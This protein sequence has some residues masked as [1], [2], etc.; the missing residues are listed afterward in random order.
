M[1]IINCLM[2]H[3]VWILLKTANYLA[4]H[5]TEAILSCLYL[6]LIC[7]HSYTIY[8]II[9]KLHYLHSKLSIFSDQIHSS[10]RFIITFPLSPQT[11]WLYSLTNMKIRFIG[12]VFKSSEDF[13][14]ISH[15][16]FNCRYSVTADFYNVTLCYT[17]SVVIK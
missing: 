5:K 6:K 12:N 16:L 7:T 2:C 14:I 1:T 10:F 17:F 8:F 13:R 11:K 4:R 3:I 9:T 15:S